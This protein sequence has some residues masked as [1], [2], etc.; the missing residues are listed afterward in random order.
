M[1]YKSNSEGQRLQIKWKNAEQVIYEL[2]TKTFLQDWCFLNPK[3]SDGKE[4]CD[5]L[6]VFE[7]TV[8]IWQIKDLKIDESWQ[9]KKQEKEKN[10]KQLW[11]AKRRLFELQSK[12]SLINNKRGQFMFDPTTIKKIYL[13]SALVW[14]GEYFWSFMEEIKSHQ[15]HVF[16]RRFIEIA[17]NELDTINDF[18]NY[19]QSKEEFLT[20]KRQ[21]I[22]NGWEEELLA[23]YLHNNRS[24]SELDSADMIILD[25]GMRKGL[26][27]KP[28]YIAKK[29]EDE[30]SYFWDFLI[31]KTHQWWDQYELVARELARA[32]RFERRYLSKAFIEG[33]INADKDN[34]HDTYRRFISMYNKW[35]T[36]CFLYQDRKDNNARKNTLINLCSVARME[37]DTPKIIG[38]ATEQHN[39]HSWWSHDFLLM[40]IPTLSDKEIKD[41]KILKNELNILQT[42]Q[43][44]SIREDEYPILN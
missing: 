4:L 13:I 38:I 15:V 30:I 8:I 25:E 36:Y 39:I 41:L 6:I 19:L 37:F 14:E 11:W 5:L 29:K 26:A 12:I 40:N 10:I 2:A 3:F 23:P 1:D 24:F 44:K 18:I 16:N 9:Y 27:N 17:L 22:I 28:E 21:I 7:D 33:N 34:M 42:P 20:K 32:S 35:V 31:D 43:Q